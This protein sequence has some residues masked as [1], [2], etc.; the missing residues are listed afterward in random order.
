MSWEN[1]KAAWDI[2]FGT[3]NGL[4]FGAVFGFVLGSIKSD[5]IFYAALGIYIAVCVV[6]ASFSAYRSQNF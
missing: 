6:G 2:R 3:C 1:T 5:T 4:I